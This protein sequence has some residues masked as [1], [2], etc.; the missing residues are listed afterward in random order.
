MTGE[1][2]RHR[3]AARLSPAAL[4]PHRPAAPGADRLL[5]RRPDPRLRRDAGLRARRSRRRTAGRSRLHPRAPA[6]A[7]QTI[8]DVPAS[9]RRALERR[10]GARGAASAAGTDDWRDRDRRSGVSQPPERGALT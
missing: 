8:D 5:L 10:D 9:E 1:R 6:L 3:R 7:A 4:L 2:P